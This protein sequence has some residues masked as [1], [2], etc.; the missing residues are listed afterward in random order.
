MSQLTPPWHTFQGK[1]DVKEAV[2]HLMGFC[3]LAVL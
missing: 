3:L 2:T 1:K